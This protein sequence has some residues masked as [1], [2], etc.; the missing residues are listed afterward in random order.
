MKVLAICGNLRNL[1]ACALQ[2]QAG[3]WMGLKE[4]YQGAD[5]GGLGNEHAGYPTNDACL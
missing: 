5:Q 2:R 3:L 4:F 1:P